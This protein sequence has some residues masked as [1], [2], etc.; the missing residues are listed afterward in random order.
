MNLAQFQPDIPQNTGTLLRMC[1]CLDIHADIIEPCGF[2]FSSKHLRRSGMD[3]LDLAEVTRHTS[4]T[5]FRQQRQL[6]EGRRVVLLTTKADELYTGF[7]FQPDDVLL[8]GSEST[9]APA[10]V[11][12]V[13]DARITIA[14]ADNTRSL[15]IAVAAAMVVGEALR[16][17]R[18]L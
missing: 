6:D 11:H 9:G 16:Q 8:L 12:D 7:R 14:M 2:V 18:E 10:Y 17:T 13:V 4:W 5:E 15:N 1:A 3:Y